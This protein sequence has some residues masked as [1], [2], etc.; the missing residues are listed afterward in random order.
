MH[1]LRGHTR[2]G[3]VRSG[4]DGAAA[5]RN[6]AENAG[7]H[8]LRQG[9][10][11]PQCHAEQ[12]GTEKPGW[13]P[14]DSSFCVAL[15]GA[16]LSGRFSE[17]AARLFVPFQRSRRRAVRRIVR[18]R[19]GSRTAAIDSECTGP[20]WAVADELLLRRVPFQVLP[21]RSAMTIRWPTTA[22][23][24]PASTGLIGSFRLRTASKKLPM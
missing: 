20:S 7:V 3:D 19:A 21:V 15:A 22:D 16:C 23:W 4:N 6:G 8:G 11:R 5:I 10:R 18:S 9:W 13:I 12:H 17:Q 1:H 2:H 24:W 14:H